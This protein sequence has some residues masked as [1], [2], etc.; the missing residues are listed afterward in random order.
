MKTNSKTMAIAVLSIASLFGACKKE[1]FRPMN[2]SDK[3]ETAQPAQKMAV[4]DQN[5]FEQTLCGRHWTVSRYDD[6]KVQARTNRTD[7]FRDYIFEFNDK[8]VVIAKG[9]EKNVVGKWNTV[10]ENGQKRLVLDFGYSPFIKLNLKWTLVNYNS[11]A[12][13]TQNVAG[14][15]TANLDLTAATNM[16]K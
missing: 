4:A 7:L 13:M 2:I 3:P 8:H 12:I 6:G 14:N 5:M 9:T 16:P 15:E 1:E 11:N 10:T